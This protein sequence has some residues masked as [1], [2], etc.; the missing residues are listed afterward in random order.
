LTDASID[1]LSLVFYTLKC[2]LRKLDLSNNRITSK[3]CSK[4]LQSLKQNE[5]LTHLSLENNPSLGNNDLEEMTMFF[6]NNERLEYL[7][8]ATCGLEEY[9][10]KD[11][12]EGLHANNL[13]N[14]KVGNQ[15]LHTLILSNNNI[16]TKGV[17]HLVT[18]L[19]YDNNTAIKY[20]D[21]A[22]NMIS[23]E[24]GIALAKAIEVSIQE[25]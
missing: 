19:E 4:L 11:M 15:T 14:F 2:K 3:G 24:G 7:N 8:L 16:K 18:L 20:L 12:V 13:N 17:M 25:F 21:L 9:H 6:K 23:D 1:D 5:F 22:S 10:V